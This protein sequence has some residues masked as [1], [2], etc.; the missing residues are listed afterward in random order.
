L[1]DAR[2]LNT[3]VKVQMRMPMNTRIPD[4]DTPKLAE[5][6]EALTPDE[7]DQLPYGVIG[8]DP[9]GVVRVYN[10]TEAQLSGRGSRPT[11]GKT[12][13]TEV[14]PCMNNPHFKGLIE[15]ARAAGTLDIRFSFVG[16]FADRNREL[17]VR[18]QS[19]K[20]G[21]TWICHHRPTS[22]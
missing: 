8:L 18:V 2:T 3:N 5:A 13:F 15:K 1:L 17:S 14:A 10:K 7:I 19:A 11:N 9:Q 22:P 6:I 16:D 12:F 4:F 21:G 20:D